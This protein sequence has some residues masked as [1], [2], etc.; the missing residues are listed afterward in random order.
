MATGGNVAGEWSYS[1]PCSAEVVKNVWNHTFTP[2]ICLHGVVF[3]QARDTSSWCC[4]WLSTET[5]FTFTYVCPSACPILIRYCIIDVSAYT[6]QLSDIENLF[7]Q[8][9]WTEIIQMHNYLSVRSVA[10]S[11]GAVSSCQDFCYHQLSSDINTPEW[12]ILRP[13]T[14]YIAYRPFLVQ[15]CTWIDICENYVSKNFETECDNSSSSDLWRPVVTTLQGVTTQ[16]N[17]T[18]IFTAVITSNLGW[19]QQT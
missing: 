16:K 12:I 17:W 18:W 14:V 5:N 9:F 2:P 13:T 10:S 19:L 1:P 4:V 15:C 11:A 8:K 7:S 6:D 3:K